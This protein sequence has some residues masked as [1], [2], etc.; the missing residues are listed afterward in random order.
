MSPG[1]AEATVVGFIGLGPMGL[2]MARNIVKKGSRLVVL[3]HRR[4]E[5]VD[6]LKTLGANEAAS[7]TELGRQC[8]VVVLCLPSSREVE[9]LVLSEGGLAGSMAKGGLLIDCTTAEPDSS[10]RVAA[11]LAAR[12]IRYVDAPLTRS[13]READA[14]TLNVLVGG[15]EADVAAARPVIDKFAENVFHIGPVGDAHKLKLINN[16][17]TIGCAAV[18]VEAVRAARRLGVDTGALFRVASLGG[19]NS[20]AFQMIMPW[21]NERDMRFRFSVANACKDVGYLNAA[22]P[23]GEV[24]TAIASLLEHAQASGDPARY[25]PILADE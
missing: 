15:S 11:A 10:L 9:S 18:V 7:V 4:R 21:V 23:P 8:P 6:E 12:G 14:G 22:S 24:A 3:G 19:A 25:L 1:A 13:S 5:P 16:F 17:L 2:G 20:G